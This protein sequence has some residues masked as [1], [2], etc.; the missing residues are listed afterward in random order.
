MIAIRDAVNADELAMAIDSLTKEIG[1]RRAAGSL[2]FQVVQQAA[3]SL[4]KAQL[5]L[6]ELVRVELRERGVSQDMAERIVTL[7]N[8]IRLLRDEIYHEMQCCADGPKPNDPAGKGS[9]D[10][11][12]HAGR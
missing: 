11:H 12:D 5:L 7:E 2:N 8:R 10:D 4:T 3:S 6:N 9:V 1:S